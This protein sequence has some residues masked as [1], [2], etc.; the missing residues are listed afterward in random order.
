ML[1]LQY[2]RHFQVNTLNLKISTPKNDEEHNLLL[3]CHG[4]NSFK[5]LNRFSRCSL[6]SMNLFQ[7][8]LSFFFLE[9]AFGFAQ[10]ILKLFIQF[11]FCMEFP[12]NQ[13]T[14]KLLFLRNT[15][16]YRFNSR[17]FLHSFNMLKWKSCFRSQFAEWKVIIQIADSIRSAIVISNEINRKMI[18]YSEFWLQMRESERDEISSAFFS[19]FTHKKLCCYWSIWIRDHDGNVN[20]A[21]GILYVV[22]EC[23]KVH[24]ISFL[25][26]WFIC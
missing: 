23:V 7:L 19:F 8:Y 2:Y 22:N 12:K 15:S 9:F 4:I 20:E 24:V 5:W 10:F 21:R 18:F 1:I 17:W 14:T 16:V 25:L 3:I 26:N 13:L 6:F 11:K